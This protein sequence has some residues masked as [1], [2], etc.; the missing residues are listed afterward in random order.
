MRAAILCLGW[1]S[2]LLAQP[3]AAGPAIQPTETIHLFDG[4]SLD[5]FYTWLQDERYSDPNHVFSVVDAIDG[6]AAVRVSGQGYGGFVTKKAY[7]NYRLVVEFRWGLLTWGKRADRSRDSGILLHAQGRPGNTQKDFNGPWMRSI[8]FQ[9][10]EGGTGDF[11]LVGGYDDSGELLAPG[12]S[13]RTRKDRD[14]ETIFDANGKQDRYTKGRINWWGRDEDWTDTLGFRGRQDVESPHGQWTHL[15]A[16]C[17][18]GR[19]TYYVN[20]KLVNEG[21]DSTL[22]E[23]HILLQTEGAEIYFRKI[24]LEPLRR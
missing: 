1:A 6:A 21:F 8:E 18:G 4:K 7:K 24:D 16:V 13:A 12:M 22:T 17:E 20:G 2:A 19:L 5:H 23:G 9:I 11:I 10:I 15:E 14:G 3:P